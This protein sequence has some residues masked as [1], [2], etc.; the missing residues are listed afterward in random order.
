[1]VG[2]LTVCV[3]AIFTTAGFASVTIWAK[4]GNRAAVRS[5]CGFEV[6]SEAVVFVSKAGSTSGEQPPNR[7]NNPTAV[8][9]YNKKSAFC[10][11]TAEVAIRLEASLS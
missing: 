7:A 4:E 11:F 3:V 2:A 5:G 6:V 8:V 9:R 10:I 1:M